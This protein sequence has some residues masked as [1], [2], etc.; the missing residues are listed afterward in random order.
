[1]GDGSR[2]NAVCNIAAGPSQLRFMRSD[3]ATRAYE[4]FLVKELESS[5]LNGLM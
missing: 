1:M 4:N 2:L 5:G 3:T